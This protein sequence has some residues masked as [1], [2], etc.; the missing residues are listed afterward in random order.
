MR[1][2]SCSLKARSSGITVVSS[3]ALNLVITSS[4]IV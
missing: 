4:S 1:K 2:A 3:V